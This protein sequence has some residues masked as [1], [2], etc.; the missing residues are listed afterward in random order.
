[1]EMEKKQKRMDEL[2]K[3]ELKKEAA[4]IL[5]EIEQDAA[6][7]NISVPEAMDDELF[8]K[9]EEYDRQQAI[10]ELL[11]DKDKEALRL[12]KEMQMLKENGTD[13]DDSMPCVSETVHGEPDEA[14]FG[15]T[16]CADKRIVRFSKKKKVYLLVAAVAVMVMGFGM[17]CIGGTPFVSKIKKQLI[18]EREMVQIDTEREDEGAVQLHEN[19]E[20]VA[21]QAINEAFGINVVRIEQKP[22]KMQFSS[23]GIDK[24]LDMAYMLYEYGK[25]TVQYQI[26]LD[27]GEQSLGYDVEDPKKKSETIAVDGTNISIWHYQ[28]QDNKEEYVAQFEN[29]SVQYMLRASMKKD[30]FVDI[31]KNLKIN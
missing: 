1:M 10:Y 13:E 19:S 25:D 26:S 18:G 23:Y 20:E 17:T 3:S 21:Y 7:Q 22:S 14:S 6:M 12:G 9:I 15:E 5:A 31:L 11:S 29:N 16:A 27:Y 24:T 28:I 8:Q 2:L 30:R 4:E